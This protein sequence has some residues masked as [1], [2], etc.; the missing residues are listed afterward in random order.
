[1]NEVTGQHIPTNE[2]NTFE[3]PDGNKLTHSYVPPTSKYPPTPHVK[4]KDPP[5]PKE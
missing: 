4:P 1:M 2:K 5:P 3:G